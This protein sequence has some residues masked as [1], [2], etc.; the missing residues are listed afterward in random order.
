MERLYSILLGIGIIA[1]LYWLGP[2]RF[3]Y[4]SE[5]KRAEIKVRI[6]QHGLSLKYYFI[7]QRRLLFFNV[8]SGGFFAVYWMYKQWQAIR[9][10]YKNTSGKVLRGGPLLRT[11]FAP[12]S[13]YQFIAILNRTCIYLRKI[14]AFP[15]VVWGTLWWAGLVTTC[16]P[17]CPV[18]GRITGGL[19]F[20]ITPYVLQGHVNNLPSK[21]PPA[22]LKW[23][24]MCCLFASWLLWAA[25]FAA[26]YKLSH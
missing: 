17:M 7:P 23:A 15:A 12:I 20:L 13:L 10:G 21:L 25:A 19:F 26:W 2:G 5:Q 14:P 24:E 11:I 8:F 3:D 16:L 18:W 4:T 22:R 6:K 1:L 9:A